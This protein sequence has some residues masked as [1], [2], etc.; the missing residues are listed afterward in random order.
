[1]ENFALFFFVCLFFTSL[2]S[3]VITIEVLMTCVTFVVKWGICWK[4]KDFLFPYV[5]KCANNPN[6]YCLYNEMLRQDFLLECSQ[7]FGFHN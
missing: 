1:M 7:H 5:P 6:A 4:G 3:V 2:R